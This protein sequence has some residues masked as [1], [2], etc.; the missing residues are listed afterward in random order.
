MLKNLDNYKI[1]LGSK[2]PRRRELLQLLRIPF[3]VVNIHNVEEKWP[4][5]MP[6]CDVPQYL[7]GI[8]ADAYLDHLHDNELII[9]ADTLVILGERIFGKPHS[10]KEACEM[11]STLSGKTHQVITGVTIATHRMRDSFTAVTDVKFGQ[12][13]ADEIRYYVDSFAPFDKAGAY[14]IQEWIGGVAVEEINGSFYNV[15]GLPIHR[16][17]RQLKNF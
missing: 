15:M 3:T 8:K 12:L 17:Y 10:A 7:S 16:L 13:S 1:L 2:S 9:T 11:L 4:E 6:A 5:G 14:G